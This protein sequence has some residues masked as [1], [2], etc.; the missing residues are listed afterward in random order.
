MNICCDIPIKFYPKHIFGE[1]KKVETRVRK[2]IFNI[3]M[4]VIIVWI[5]INWQYAM[6]YYKKKCI[7][8][9]LINKKNITFA[10]RLS[11]KKH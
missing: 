5:L 9:Q 7:F 11:I 2:I 10:Y 6:D 4:K 3:F 8:A 1:L